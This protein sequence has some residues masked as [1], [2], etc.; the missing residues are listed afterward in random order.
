MGQMSIHVSPE[1]R[2][3]LQRFGNQVAKNIA[4]KSRDELTKEFA[5]TITNFYTSYAPTQYERNWQLYK[6]Y[7][8]YYQ[9]AHGNIYYGGVRILSDKMQDLYH[10]S[11]DE[12]LSTVLEGFHGRSNRWIQTEPAPL[13]HIIKFRDSLIAGIGVWGPSAIHSARQ[14]GGYSILYR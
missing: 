14:V 4:T 11:P 1:L 12:V 8:K 3:D 9:N 2:K 10:D 13:E 5:W 7:E 6:A